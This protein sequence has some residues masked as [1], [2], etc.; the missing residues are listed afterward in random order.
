MFNSIETIKASGFE[1]FISFKELINNTYIIPKKPG[2]YMV[3]CDPLIPVKFLSIG[4]GGHFKK[5][6]PNVLIQE[7]Q[8]NWIDGAIVLNIGKA[9]GT[10]SNGAKIK[11]HLQSRLKK[12]WKFGNGK[13]IGHWGGRYIWQIENSH[14]LVVCWKTITDNEPREIEEQLIQQFKLA[15]GNRPFA[16]LKD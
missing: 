10:R 8:I 6:D 13:R 7:L 11:E 4:T 2:V 16:N 14:N 15:Y 1:G 9:G 3:L 5:K 12:Y